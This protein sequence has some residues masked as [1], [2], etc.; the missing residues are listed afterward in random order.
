[1]GMDTAHRPVGA[2]A[3]VT[4]G[5]ARPA[6]LLTPEERLHAVAGILRR[7]LCRRMGSRKLLENG[8]TLERVVDPCLPSAPLGK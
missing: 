7:G 4:E 3:H 1:M 8:A 2:P 6:D 5:L